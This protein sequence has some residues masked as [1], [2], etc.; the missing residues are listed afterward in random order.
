MTPDSGPP[1]L[2]LAAVIRREGRYL[3]GRRPESK[4]H[5]GLWEFPGGKVRPDEGSRAGLAREL[6]EELGI[7]LV[8]VGRILFERRDP[9]SPF[10]IRFVEVVAEGE[11]RTLEHTQ[12]VWE[13]PEALGRRALAPTDA[14]FVREVLR[15]GDGG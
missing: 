8:S 14:A 9:G 12:L 5:A 1:T 3:V 10:L 4:R 7:E 13:S 11:P 2:V 15:D 6:R